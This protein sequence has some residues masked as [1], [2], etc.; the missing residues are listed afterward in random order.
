[1]NT[2]KDIRLSRYQRFGDWRYSYLNS[3]RPRAV[4]RGQVGAIVGHAL[5]SI[6]SAAG[7]GSMF[8]RDRASGVT[9]E[10][11]GFEGDRL[12]LMAE[13]TATGVTP[14]ASDALGQSEQIVV[15]DQLLVALSTV[16]D[17]HLMV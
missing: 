11:V 14:G 10:V 6:R 8:Y 3:C 9:A 13:S 7:I 5:R 4:Y 16:L 12:I 2:A 17:D 15:G 1:M